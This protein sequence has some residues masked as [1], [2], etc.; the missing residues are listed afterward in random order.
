[1]AKRHTNSVGHPAD[2]SQI[3]LKEGEDVRTSHSKF[4]SPDQRPAKT[5]YVVDKKGEDTLVTH[6]FRHAHGQVSIHERL[7]LPNFVLDRPVRLLDEY[8]ALGRV[9]VGYDLVVRMT[10]MLDQMVQPVPLRLAPIKV[11]HVVY[12]RQLPAPEYPVVGF[13]FPRDGLLCDV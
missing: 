8:F 10:P 1:L 3:G 6:M 2:F 5:Q 13:V 4:C 7:S 11:V 9:T 12:A